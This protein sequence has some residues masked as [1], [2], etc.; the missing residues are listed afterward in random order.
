MKFDYLLIDRA[1]ILSTEWY[2]DGVLGLGPLAAPS[3]S[4]IVR[5]KSVIKEMQMLGLIEKPIFSFEMGG[6]TNLLHLG[7]ISH[8]MLESKKRRADG[9]SGKGPEF[10]WFTNTQPEHWS[11]Y[12]W[13]IGM[14]GPMVDQGKRH[15]LI[16]SGTS[17]LV[18][19]QKQYNDLEE[20]LL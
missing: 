2:F 13:Y 1:K 4:D 17:M 11:M 15:A 10:I 18:I 12:S 8:Q 20:Q 7:G 5:P 6:K 14:N 16:D 3:N 9:N 19:P